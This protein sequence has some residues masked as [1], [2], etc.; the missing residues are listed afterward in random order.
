M[1]LARIRSDEGGAAAIEYAL[2]LPVFITVTVGALC[3][4]NLAFAINS[5]HYAVQDA[6]RCSAVK[7]TICTDTTATLTYAKSRYS[8][9]KIGPTFTYSSAGCGHTVSATGSYPIMLA[10]YSVNV[11]ISASACYPG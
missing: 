1:R 5:L 7:T 11:P 4:A 10:A 9:P 8:G 3:A 6:A 2:V